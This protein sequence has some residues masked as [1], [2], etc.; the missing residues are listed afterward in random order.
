MPRRMMKTLATF[1]LAAGGLCAD[2]RGVVLLIGPPGAGK[3]TQA[4]NLSRKYKIPSISMS[5]LLKKDA[6]WNKA[7][8]KKIAKAEVESGELA[9]DQVADVLMRKRVMQRTMRSADSFWTG[10]RP[11]RGRPRI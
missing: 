1:L 5:E 3:S 4:R 10:I 9:N 2:T 11:R 7:G 8:S 6:G